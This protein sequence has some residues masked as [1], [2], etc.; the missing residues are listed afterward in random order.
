MTKLL[1][2]WGRFATTS[3]FLLVSVLDDPGEHLS[4]LLLDGLMG[5]G[6]I[7]CLLLS[8]YLVS[9]DLLLQSPETGAPLCVG[10]VGTTVC[11]GDLPHRPKPGGGVERLSLGTFS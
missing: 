11:V 7:L 2:R 3:V 5:V 1:T 6:F 9:E 4:V 10:V 8:L